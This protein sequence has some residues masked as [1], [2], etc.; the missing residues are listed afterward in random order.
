MAP[1]PVLPDPVLPEPVPV[2]PAAPMVPPEPSLGMPVDPPWAAAPPLMPW[3]SQCRVTRSPACR[4]WSCEDAE[5]DTISVRVS[6]PAL[7][8]AVVPAAPPLD[9]ALRTVIVP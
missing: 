5:P 6:A 9:D 7:L 1:P 4:P 2:V 8:P 3:L